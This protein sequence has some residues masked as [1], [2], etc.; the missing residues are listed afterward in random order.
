MW[1][2]HAILWGC[3]VTTTA[4]DEIALGRGGAD[5]AATATEGSTTAFRLA[6]IVLEDE[7]IVG[8][9]LNFGAKEW[10]IRSL[11]APLGH[12]VAWDLLEAIV[13]ADGLVVT[14]VAGGVGEVVHEPLGTGGSTV[15]VGESGDHEDIGNQ[16]KAQ[17]DQDELNTL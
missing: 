5:T 8:S 15:V 4:V 12:A 1:G 3:A 2:L 7:E 10:L 11:L 17:H 16:Q 9:D 13:G 6:L 14:G